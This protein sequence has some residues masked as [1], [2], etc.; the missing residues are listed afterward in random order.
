MSAGT[1]R[2]DL[3][4]ALG[5]L[6]DAFDDAFDEAF[7]DAFTRTLAHGFAIILE[8]IFAPVFGFIRGLGLLLAAPVALALCVVRVLGGVFALDRVLA[9]VN[10]DAVD[11]VWALARTRAA[12]R[13]RAL[14]PPPR[15]PRPRPRSRPRSCLRSR[16]RP[17]SGRGSCPGRRSYSRRPRTAQR[18]AGCTLGVWSAGCRRSPVAGR[19]ARPVCRGVCQRTVG[20]GPV[21]VRPL[22]AIAICAPPASQCPPDGLRAAIPTP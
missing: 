5:D 21:R 2:F 18:Y 11:R 7:N 13:D 8:C 9:D 19:R 14:G 10:V 16:P 1:L 15:V 12:E 17:P 4:A 20:S 3:D 22:G 6:D